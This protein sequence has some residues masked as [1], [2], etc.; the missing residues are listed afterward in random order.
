MMKKIIPD[1][2]HCRRP[3]EGLPLRPLRGGADQG[4]GGVLGPLHSDVH[5]GGNDGLQVGAH[6][7]KGGG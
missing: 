3:R 6:M 2:A 1:P 7:G 5:L 4:D